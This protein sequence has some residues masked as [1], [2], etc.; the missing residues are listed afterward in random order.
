MPR[1]R[2]DE[3]IIGTVLVP[4][5]TTRRWMHRLPSHAARTGAMTGTAV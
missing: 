4:W 3:D 5:L 1:I 2:L